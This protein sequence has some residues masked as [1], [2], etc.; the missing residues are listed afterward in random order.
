[1]IG[2]WEG[3]LGGCSGFVDV[4]VSAFRFGVGNRSVLRGPYQGRQRRDGKT[5]SYTE[6][7]FMKSQMQEYH[8]KTIAESSDVGL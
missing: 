3:G 4:W 7:E 5:Q 1:M 2:A 8:E 6:I